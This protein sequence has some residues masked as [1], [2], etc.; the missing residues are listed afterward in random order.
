MANDYEER[1][2][3]EE[4]EAEDRRRRDQDEE[5]ARRIRNMALGDMMNTGI[6]GGID[7]NPFTPF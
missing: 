5:D 3:R 7:M 4:Q 2:K 6:P 1:R